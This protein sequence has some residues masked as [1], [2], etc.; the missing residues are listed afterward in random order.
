VI[1]TRKAINRRTVLKGIG[2]ALALPFL[3]SMVPAMQGAPKPVNRFGAVYVPN[4]INMSTWTPAADGGAFDL[5]P[6][7]KPLAPFR[8]RL[9]VLSGLNS[10]LP[11]KA[12]GPAGIHARA[13]T[14]FLT[15]VPPK[16]AEAAD[17]QAGVSMDQL[18]A[19]ESGK[20]TQLASIELGLESADQV[21]VC[22]PGF[23]CAYTS[24][25]SWRSATTPLPTEINPRAV[26]E[27]MFGDTGST[28]PA[29]RL[30]RMRQ[31]RSILDAVV[32][33][34][35]RLS[36]DLG[37]VDRVKLNEYC[38]AIR[39]VERR[40]QRAEEQNAR[41]LPAMNP[42][43]GIPSG[44]DEHAALMYDLMALAYQSDLTRVVT[45]MIGH[46]Y[47]GRTHPEI[48]ITDAHHAI[49]HH[50]GDPITLAKLTKVDTHHVELF[51][52]LLEKLGATPDGDGS[53]LDHT[54]FLYGSGMSDGNAHDPKNLPVLLLGGASASIQGGRH[55]RFPKDTPLANLHLTLLGKMGLPMDKIGDST[56]EFKELTAV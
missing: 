49:S 19:R 23:N 44:F 16:P 8:D 25:I 48:G 40:I 14:R 55:L 26:F 13:C 10:N 7:L 37:P 28:D 1:I 54:I 22:D 21:G 29:A 34:A 50:K 36:R 35:A 38:D 42:P 45:F 2:T 52:K 5:T 43:T 9:L 41:E 27:R 6:S 32:A 11:A 33:K 31:E 30:A 24:T 4:G 12:Q 39:D 51:A 46:E 3:D 17:M 20:Y 56:G 18:I 53:L 47:S 15:D